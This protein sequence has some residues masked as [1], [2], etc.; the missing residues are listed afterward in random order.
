MAA[1]ARSPERRLLRKFSH[2][3]KLS[4]VKFLGLQLPKTL[5]VSARSSV[6]SPRHRAQA[7]RPGISVLWVSLSSVQEARTVLQDPGWAPPMVSLPSTTVLGRQLYAEVIV[8]R[9]LPPPALCSKHRLRLPRGPAAAPGPWTSLLAGVPASIPAFM[10][11]YSFPSSSP[12]SP[13]HPLW[14]AR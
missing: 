2:W 7:G 6:A 9:P 1:E 14:P 8:C 13:D 11:S 10:L 12:S 5:P 3:T 4:Q